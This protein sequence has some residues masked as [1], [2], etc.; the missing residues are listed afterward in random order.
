MSPLSHQAIFELHVVDIVDGLGSFADP[1]GRVLIPTKCA[2]D[3]APYSLVSSS[4]SSKASISH[5]VA[6]TASPLRRIFAHSASAFE[7]PDGVG[8]LASVTSSS[9]R[10]RCFFDDSRVC[11]DLLH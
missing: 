10:R 2:V 5:G 1:S 7:V 4:G 9:R 8:G 6:R 3:V 11:L